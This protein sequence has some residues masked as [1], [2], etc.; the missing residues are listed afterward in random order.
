MVPPHGNCR[1]CRPHFA[2]SVGSSPYCCSRP[3]AGE[4]GG[5][6]GVC[7]EGLLLK[8]VFQA[9]PGRRSGSQLRLP[10]HPGELLGRPLQPA[11]ER[12]PG[13]SR[14]LLQ[15]SL[16]VG[17]RLHRRGAIL[18]APRHH[19]PAI[20]GSVNPFRTGNQR[21]LPL[22]KCKWKLTVLDA[23]IPGGGRAGNTIYAACDGG[24]QDQPPLPHPGTLQ[25]SRL[26][27]PRCRAAHRMFAGVADRM[28]ARMKV[29]DPPARLRQALRIWFAD[30]L[31]HVAFR[32]MVSDALGRHRWLWPVL[33]SLTRSLSSPS[34]RLQRLQS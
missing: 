31:Q 20:A 9:Q 7:L 33:P 23:P 11:Q 14:A 18:R 27:T 5:V 28:I 1:D 34:W 21:D 2:C 25:A 24:V 6:R 16:P 3:S 19:D 4:A 30:A 26:P 29:E 22:R 12:P 13:P 17:Q 8:D 32:S 15:I 10:G